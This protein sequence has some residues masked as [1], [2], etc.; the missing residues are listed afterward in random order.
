METPTKSWTLKIT[1]VIRWT[2]E[3]FFS[4]EVAGLL[5]ILHQP[6]PGPSPQHLPDLLVA[7]VDVAAVDEGRDGVD[8]LPPR[9]AT[10]GP[11][12]REVDTG[13]TRILSHWE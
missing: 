3:L 2:S 5:V 4:W 7:A 6:A 13:Y 1:Q 10:G 9:L 8:L 12:A 11:R